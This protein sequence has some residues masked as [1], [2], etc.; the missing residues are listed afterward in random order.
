MASAA[1][2]IHAEPVP[3]REGV[4]YPPDFINFLRAQENDASD[5]TLNDERAVALSFY[6]GEPFGNEEEG[7]SQ[8]VTRDVAEVSNYTLISI[9][10]TMT[11]GDRVVELEAMNEQDTEV[12]EEANEAI[13]QQFMYGQDG[14]RF[15]HDT[16][17]SGILEKTGAGKTFVERKKV[18]REEI[19][20]D[21]QYTQLAEDESFKPIAFEEVPGVLDELG[22]PLFKVAWLEEGPTIFSDVAIPNEELLVARDARSIEEAVYVAHKVRKTVSEL[23]LMGF[24]FDDTTLE[25]GRSTSTSLSSARDDGTRDDYGYRDGPN[26]VCWLLEEYVYYDLNGDGIAEFLRVQRVGQQI[27]TC[28]EI[29]FGLIDEWCPMPMQHRR[30]GQSVADNCMDIQ[31]VRSVFLRQTFDNLYL[32]NAPRTLLPESAIGDTTID[33]LL[34][35]RP[36]A[37][38]RYS[39]AVAPTPI[40]TPFVAESSFQALEFMAGERESRTGVTR[41]N[42]GLEVGE[43]KNDTATA[44]QGLQ[45]QGQQME[46]Y[47]TH[48]YAEFLARIFRKKYR[49]M[50]LFGQPFQIVVDDKPKTVD[51]RN[52]PDDIRVKIKVG[53]GAGRPAARVQSRMLLASLQEKAAMSDIPITNAMIYNNVKG[54]V[55]DL[56]LGTPTD[57]WPGPDTPEPEP[58]PDPATLKAQADAQIAAQKLQQEQAKQQQDAELKAQQMQIDAAMKQQQLDYDLQAKREKAALDEQLARDK[59]VFEANLAQQQADREYDLALQRLA[60]DREVAKERNAQQAELS[61][62]REGGALDK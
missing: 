14:Y 49:L 42:Q 1:L 59:A 12:V 35:T 52:W 9:L 3:E 37:L 16:L 39:G 32:T 36:G 25:Y 57:Y 30:V 61:R 33:D 44:F 4:I 47:Y 54:I 24:E 17:K 56:K 29:E 28:D 53:L 60:M 51:P 5:T 18:R 8:V 46:E 6:R 58:Q 41:L 45:A 31:L 11:S 23:R 43:T 19:M 2:N 40:I 20:S 38:V 27:F 10:R 62:K 26:R 22:N 21:L 55:K 15:L 50:K 34:T 7:R 48:N 13:I